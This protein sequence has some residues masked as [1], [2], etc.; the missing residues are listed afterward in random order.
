VLSTSATAS[1][2]MVQAAPPATRSNGP[3]TGP[4]P[5]S[6][7]LFPSSWMV[8]MV[9]PT[10]PPPSDEP[11][12]VDPGAP[13]ADGGASGPWS[14]PPTPRGLAIE[15]QLG[16]NLP[17]SFPTIDSFNDGMATSI[18]S[19]DLSASSY[20]NLN[21]LTSKLNGYVNQVAGFN[22][23]TFDGVSNRIER[24]HQPTTGYCDPIWGS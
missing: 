22:G 8:G 2:R 4:G 1:F 20:Q 18:K 23:A 6:P 15:E 21:T 12:V 19:V 5:Q 11:P 16:G 10:P 7:S 3:P 14:L 24:D 17:P 13:A 9:I